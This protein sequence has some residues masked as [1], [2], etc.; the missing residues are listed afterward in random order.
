MNR[1]KKTKTKNKFFLLCIR[2][3]V[4]IVL[5]II[6]NDDYDILILEGMDRV[7]GLPHTWEIYD[8]YGR[9]IDGNK[10]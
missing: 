10:K 2:D 8:T 3:E 6:P 1:K 4:G 5:D 9:Y 7:H